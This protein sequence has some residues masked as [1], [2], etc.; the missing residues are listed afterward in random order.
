MDVTHAAGLVPTKMHRKMVS[1]QLRVF[2][3]SG[4][5]VSAQSVNKIVAGLKEERR[6]EFSNSKVSLLSTSIAGGDFVGCKHALTGGECRNR[7]HFAGNADAHILWC[8]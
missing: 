8:S 3:Y 6:A 7:T 2:P 4:A 1:A 5:V